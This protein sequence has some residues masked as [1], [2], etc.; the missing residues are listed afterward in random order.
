MRRRLAAL[1]AAAALV[2][3]ACADE[4]RDDPLG[5][6]RTGDVDDRDV[7]DRSADD[8]RDVDDRGADDD[9]GAAD[10][11]RPELRV[12]LLDAG[13]EPRRVLRLDPTDGCE[14]PVTLR[15]AVDQRVAVGE[16]EQAGTTAFEY[17]ITYRCESVE[18]DRIEVSVHYDDARIDDA[19]PRS[20]ESLEAMVQNL[21]GAEGRTVFDRRGRILELDAP[22]VSIDDEVL[23]E[24]FA[25]AMEQMLESMEA[26]ID[27]SATPF[28]E[29]AVGLGARWRTTGTMD[30][31]GM[32]TRLVT[33]L[34]VTEL[35]AETV[36]AASTLTMEIVPGPFRMEGLPG[37]AE[38]VSGG[39]TGTGT[40]TWRLGH[41]VAEAEQVMDGESVVRLVQGGET[42]EL[43]Q[44]T[45]QENAVLPR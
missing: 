18:A 32:R 44:T 17:D 43:V 40:V 37:A 34:T 5:G 35:S 8:D 7:D 39:F 23:G 30:V 33:E 14:Q 29:E 4:A 31:L 24:Q 36:T 11:D 26:S 28:P 3:G 16:Q 19:D 25:D 1:L 42:V 15:N 20:R 2:L 41:L 13:A 45:H 9:G 12:E 10:Q 22:Q 38:I 6:A 27:Q 21:V